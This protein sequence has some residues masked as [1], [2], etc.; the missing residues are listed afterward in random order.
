ML[1]HNRAKE[2]KE[3]AARKEQAAKSGKG[4][5]Q[6]TLVLGPSDLTTKDQ[7][8][9]T[10]GHKSY[11]YLTIKLLKAEG[12]RTPNNDMCSG[13]VQRPREILDR[14]ANPTFNIN[15]V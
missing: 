3:E 12:L 1:H 14:K 5:K 4:R 15:T 7:I 6:S 13:L 9:T 10:S 2:R 8:L 11:E